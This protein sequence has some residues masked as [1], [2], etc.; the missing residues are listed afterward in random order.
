[1]PVVVIGTKEG[2]HI[3]HWI[4][5]AGFHIDMVLTMNVLGNM[6]LIRIV[7]VVDLPMSIL[8]DDDVT[9]VG[10]L[11]MRDK[12]TDRGD[13]IGAE[14]DRDGMVFGMECASPG[15]I[16]EFSHTIYNHHVTQVIVR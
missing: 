12:T 3:L 15:N 11:V 9:S 16:L 7:N 1:M 14:W 13:L 2:G 5:K 8:S 10:V 4:I 6:I